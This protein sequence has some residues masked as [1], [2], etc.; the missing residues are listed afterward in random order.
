MAWVIDGVLQAQ[1]ESQE[2]VARVTMAMIKAPTLE[3]L[4]LNP[5]LAVEMHLLIEIIE[6]ADP[7]RSPRAG[8][9]LAEVRAAGDI[10]KRGSKTDQYSSYDKRSNI[11]SS[12]LE[13]HARYCD[14]RAP[15]DSR[16]SAHAVTDKTGAAWC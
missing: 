13:C 1:A 16:A 12:T 14:D 15:E 8:K 11:P 5:A 6:Q 4:A 2:V 7:P 9:R 3:L 10:G